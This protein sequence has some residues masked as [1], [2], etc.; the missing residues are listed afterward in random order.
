MNANEEL[1]HIFFRSLKSKNFIQ[2]ADC[3]AKNATFTNP[4]YI[5]L[6]K[7]LTVA[8]F[9]MYIRNAE[10]LRLDFKN[11]TA[12][13]HSGSAEWLITYTTAKK[14]K[15][16]IKYLKSHFTFKNEKIVKQVDDF[17]FYNYIRQIKGATGFMFGWARL[18]KTSVQNSAM[19]ELIRF[20]D[21]DNFKISENHR[22]MISH[23]HQ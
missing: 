6:N 13:H 5:S 4:V 1:L 21:N 12:D 2:L 17:N 11:I 23:T 8:M 14:N 15:V 20:K 9:N 22:E 7:T 18:Y 3:Y 16:V 19:K 10:N